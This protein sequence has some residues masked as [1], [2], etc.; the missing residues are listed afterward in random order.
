[1]ETVSFCPD[2]TLSVVAT[3]TLNGKI[4]FWDIPSQIERQTYEQNAGV[5]KMLWHPQKPY[6]LFS[7]GLDGIIRL[8]DSRNGTLVH[9]YTGHTANILD[10]ALSK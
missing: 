8:I 7:A 5:V 3:G 4:S 2:T 1:M 9:E 6:L 10:I